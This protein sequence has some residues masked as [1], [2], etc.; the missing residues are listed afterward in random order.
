MPGWR[1]IPPLVRHCVVAV[2]NKGATGGGA[3]GVVRACRLCRDVLAKQGHLYHRSG[4][5]VLA[6]I[7]LTGKGWVRNQKHIAEGFAGSAK[8]LA[9]EKLFKMVEPKLYELD[10]PG[11]AKPPAPVKDNID[12]EKSGINLDAPPKIGTGRLPSSK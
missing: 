12:E 9:F 11:G 4:D 2:F 8:D 1:D 6:G 5:A 10:G 7:Q 3:D